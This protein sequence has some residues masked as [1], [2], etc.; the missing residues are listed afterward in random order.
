MTFVP[1]EIAVSVVHESTVG[2]TE[3]E[4]TSVSVNL[5]DPDIGDEFVVDIYFDE[6]Y[7]TFI[8]HTVAGISKCIHEENTARSEDP[9]L[10]LL[11]PA[12]SFIYPKE[13]MVFEVEMTN[14][15]L[16]PDSFFYIAQEAGSRDLFVKADY[17]G[18]NENGLVIQLY[19]DTPVIKQI[20][21]NRGYKKYEF[22]NLQLTLKSKCEADMNVRQNQND[23][24]Y[25]T[26]TLSNAVNA[27]GEQVLKW[28]EPCPELHWAGE[29]KR[30]RY[31]LFSTLTSEEGK[32]DT[33]PVKIFNPSATIGK[34]ITKLSADGPL[35]EVLFK[36]RPKGATVWKTGLTKTPT[37]S[38]EPMNFLLPFVDEDPYGFSSLDW[39]LE[40]KVSQGDYE[41]MLESK[42]E[43]P[44]G[45]DEVKGFQE[46]I[47]TGIYDIASPE[48]YGKPVPLR[49]DVI[50]GEEISIYF[51]EEMWCKQPYSFDMEVNIIGTNYNLRRDQLFIN[52]FGKKLGF[53][54]D[55][56]VG[57]E[58][59]EII[60][61]DFT[62]E[63]GKIGAGSLSKLMDKNFNPMD[64]LKGNIRFS[65]RFANLDLSSATSAFKFSMN[66]TTCTNESVETQSDDVRHEIASIIGIDSVERIKVSGLN[67]QDNS[68]VSANAEII[69]SSEERLLTSGIFLKER[70]MERKISIE[71]FH[72]L[73]DTVTG[74]KKDTSRRLL[75]EFMDKTYHVK[76]ML[77]VPSLSDVA[78][79]DSSEEEKNE[80][81]ELEEWAADTKTSPNI[82][83]ETTSAFLE[84]KKILKYNGGYQE[85]EFQKEREQLENEKDKLLKEKDVIMKEAIK[86]K[87][88]MLKEKD[89]IM[90]EA[91]KEKNDI[92]LEMVKE[93]NEM[94]EMIKTLFRKD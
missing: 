87:N 46:S 71:L 16:S 5:G 61:K 78:K 86:E 60:G 9:K 23:G 12:S 64:P 65:K 19:K 3:E 30:D 85:E 81:S 79:F 90:K 40:G 73:Q 14:L 6:I 28:M 11:N 21:I 34:N 37:G 72:V 66:N 77:F 32:D 20:A 84:D 53:Q 70:Q 18:V 80:E 48:Q 22:P 42:C 75:N 62:V 24:M 4:S 33:L 26:I 27:E 38:T 82:E 1:A 76:E 55:L 13:S 63:I 58:I 92:L 50:I 29:L 52:C 69:P 74:K 49:H 89:V 67:C 10:I 83:E 35:K 54:L 51:T 43:S 88:E 39:L 59:S 68:T 47:I 36:Y 91:L 56:S 93:K 25:T 94:K 57:I 17:N 31:F 15:G 44:G 41:I 8:F 2:D 45:P 7:G